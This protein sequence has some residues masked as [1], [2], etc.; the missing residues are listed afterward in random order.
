L[1][2]N[3]ALLLGYVCNRIIGLFCR[4]GLRIVPGLI[5]LAA[6]GFDCF[7]ILG[8]TLDPEDLSAAGVIDPQDPSLLTWKHNPEPFARGPC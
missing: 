1:A 3:N 2:A 4:Q 7:K 5:Y 8:D 6:A